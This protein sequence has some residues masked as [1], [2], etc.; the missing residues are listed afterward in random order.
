MLAVRGLALALLTLSVVLLVPPALAQS[1]FRITFEVDDSRP[2]RARLNGRL[3]NERPND[4][5][6]VSVTAEALDAN[7]KVV[8]RGISYVDARIARGD[9]RSFSVTVP[10]VP[11]TTSYRVV[12]S[13]FRGG[14]MGTP[15]S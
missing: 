13:S 12:V 1:G 7:G 9:T 6:E 5:F 8:A 14:I 11:G 10:A 15:Q 3:T 2:G 4:V